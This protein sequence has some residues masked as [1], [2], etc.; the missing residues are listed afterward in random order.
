MV[1]VLIAIAAISVLAVLAFRW[2]DRYRYTDAWRKGEL[3]GV[4]FGFLMWFGGIFGHRVPPPPRSRV[5]FAAG[6]EREPEPGSD[7]PP[8]SQDA[9]HEKQ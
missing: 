1:P 5:E 3:R 6:R 8:L 2:F 9:A 7:G 4:A